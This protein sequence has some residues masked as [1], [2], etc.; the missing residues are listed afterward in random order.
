MTTATLIIEVQKTKRDVYNEMVKLIDA[1]QDRTPRYRELGKRLMNCN[2][3][4]TR[5]NAG[6]NN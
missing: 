3:T 6:P 4:L 1:G 5:L 2:K